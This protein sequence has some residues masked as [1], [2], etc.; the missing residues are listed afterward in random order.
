MTGPTIPV[1]GP[2]S[3][4]AFPAAQLTHRVS[5]IR[6]NRQLVVCDT[7][8]TDKVAGAR[9]LPLSLVELLDEGLP[10][11]SI[12]TCYFDPGVPSHPDAARV[13]RIAAKHL[14]GRGQF[15]DRIDD[16]TGWLTAPEGRQHVLVGYA[17]AF[18]AEP[19]Y[20]EFR[21]A[22][23][24]LPPLR[25]LDTRRARRSGR[26]ARSHRRCL[27]RRALRR[28]RCRAQQRPHRQRRPPA[29]RHTSCSPASPPICARRRV[30]WTAWQPL[31]LPCRC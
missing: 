18:D 15:A 5:R 17:P 26:R 11:Q 24:E 9:I 12:I 10:G 7:E 30:G 16:I 31:R 28:A 14:R 6:G 22:G 29:P 27:P 21:L 23:R 2:V 1:S 20:H 4:V 8:T 25:L 13:H 19:L 3:P